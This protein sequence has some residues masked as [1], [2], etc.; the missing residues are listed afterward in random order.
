MEHSATSSRA[1]SPRG[2][3]SSSNNGPRVNN[4]RSRAFITETGEVWEVTSQPPTKKTRSSG[5]F[6]GSN[7]STASGSPPRN[8]RQSPSLTSPARGKRSR[9]PSDQD[10]DAQPSSP[11]RQMT[12]VSDLDSDQAVGLRRQYWLRSSRSERQ[13]A[14]ASRDRAHFT[15][16]GLQGI[17]G[18]D[19][20]SGASRSASPVELE[21]E[22]DL[23]D[24]EDDEEP[25]DSGY[26]RPAAI[27]EE[28]LEELKDAEEYEEEE[29]A[30]ARAYNSH[31]EAQLGQEND[32]EEPATD[33]DLHR[34]NSLAEDQYVAAAGGGT[35]SAD[36]T[37]RDAAWNQGSRVEVSPS[38]SPSPVTRYRLARANSSDSES[39]D[40]NAHVLR[41][42]F[43]GFSRPAVLIQHQ[44][45]AEQYLAS[46]PGYTSSSAISPAPGPV[47][48]VES[49]TSLLSPVTAAVQS[50][51]S[52]DD[53]DDSISPVEGVEQVVRS[54]EMEESST[55]SHIA[56]PFYEESSSEDEHAPA[57]SLPLVACPFIEES[58]SEDEHVPASSLP[59]V[60]DSSTVEESTSSESMMRRSISPF[61]GSVLASQQLLSELQRYAD[62]ERNLD[63]VK[64]SSAQTFSGATTPQATALPQTSPAQH[65]SLHVYQQA[66][67]PPTF[68]EEEVQRMMAVHSADGPDE[69]D[70]EVLRLAMEEIENLM[71]IDDPHDHEQLFASTQDD[72]RKRLRQNRDLEA[73]L[74]RQQAEAQRRAKTTRMHLDE[75]DPDSAADDVE[76]QEQ[77]EDY[78]FELPGD[79]LRSLEAQRARLDS[80]REH[81]FTSQ[82][83]PSTISPGQ[84][85]KEAETL[86]K[87]ENNATSA[88]ERVYWSNRKVKAQY[89]AKG[90]LRDA[91]NCDVHIRLALV[92]W[93]RAIS[94]SE[95]EAAAFAEQVSQIQ[96]GEEDQEAP[97]KAKLKPF[98]TKL[99]P[100][101]DQKVT[102]ILN[103]SQPGKKIAT[104]VDGVDLTRKDFATIIHAANYRSNDPEGWLN[105]EIINGFFSALCNALNEKAGVTKGKIPLFA[106]YATSWYGSVT[107]NGIKAIGRWSRRKGIQGEKLLQC[108][109]IFFPVNPGNH[110]SLLV[111]CPDIHTIEY[112]DSLD[113]G[114]FRKSTRYAT[115]GREWLEM[116][117][118]EKYVEDEWN[119]VDR[120]SALQ[121]NGSDCGVFTCLNGVTS[122][123]EL[124]NPTTMFGPEEIPYAR[125]A[126]VSMFDLGGFKSHFE[127]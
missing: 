44:A 31:P 25:V 65:A 92:A 19:V 43:T 82:P 62:D 68:S 45:R 7:T 88:D 2:S 8:Q 116:E 89:C 118:G 50:R 86:A 39:D 10:F 20:G 126:M 30:M 5:Q 29:A 21:E 17:S 37:D 106:T 97:L 6:T 111:I 33:L 76:E 41:H 32:E 103:I 11:K 120:R 54:V 3:S 51:A 48:A 35:Y 87:H 101:L 55:R 47:T 53:D 75:A 122:A 95:E 26:S 109:R 9:D 60:N 78:I 27:V 42:S 99:P 67:S 108:K 90:E 117:L 57:P 123:L 38:R 70:I 104:S 28:E 69:E 94:Q 85:T 59:L 119:V 80:A 22:L 79:D 12:S 100:E 1:G 15:S 52:A 49:P 71:E 56:V 13:R 107:K 36:G 124:S 91:K 58:S 77:P 4:K 81:W 105:D 66:P 96:L 98:L 61:T 115:L 63:E 125:R 34:Y 18:D 72:V 40:G 46:E 110:W 93:Q 16:S 84:W 127:L 74:A 112:L 102:E 83:H 23:P 14:A 24:Y 73:Q 114:S 121:N 64:S 113:Q